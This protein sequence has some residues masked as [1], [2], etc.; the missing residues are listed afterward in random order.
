M[1]EDEGDGVRVTVRDNG[2]GVEP[3][4][5]DDSARAG[6]LGVHQSIRGRIRDLGGTTGIRSRPGRG[7]EVELWVPHRT[8]PSS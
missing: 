3:G 7:T 4:R 5:L 8:R 2:I 6:R 1:L